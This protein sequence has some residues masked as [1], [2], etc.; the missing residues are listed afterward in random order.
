MGFCEDPNKPFTFRYGQCVHAVREP[1]NEHDANAVTIHA[2]RPSK[3]IGHVNKQRAAWV[4][5]LL[6]A[7]QEL[8]GIVIQSKD[9]SPR[10]PLTTPEML[11]YL[12]RD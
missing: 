4:A 11:T 12:Q 5:K 9:A 8:D 10:V 1:D 6:H 7:G 2:G 3:K